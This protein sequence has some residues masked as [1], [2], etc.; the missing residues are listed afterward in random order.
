MRLITMMKMNNP[1]M[2]PKM[3]PTTAKVDKKELLDE[4]LLVQL[5]HDL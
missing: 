3:M 5:L 2:I 4:S 1:A